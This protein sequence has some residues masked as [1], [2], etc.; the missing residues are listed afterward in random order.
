MALAR[1]QLRLLAAL[2]C[3]GAVVWLS[4]GSR[5][6]FGLFLQP[7][8]S[9]LGWGREVF[10]FALAL[11]NLMWGLAQ[12]FAGMVADRYGSG[13]VLVAG[14]AVYALGLV[15]MSQTGAAWHFHLGAGVLVGLALAATSFAVVLSAVGRLVAPERRGLAFGIVTAVGSFGQFA[16]VP[17][18]Q[19]FLAAYGWPTAFLILAAFALL[20]VPLAT[21]LTGR[22][23]PPDAGGSQ[24][25][26]QAL[27]EAAH[28]DGFRY[29]TLG[30]FVCGFQVA[31]IAVHLPASLADSGIATSVAAWAL[32]LVGLFNVVGSLGCGV[33]GDRFSKK[34]LLSLL[35][36][37][38]AVVIVAFLWMPLSTVSVL[39]FA[40]VM[41]LLWLGTVP[42]TS[43]LVSQIFGTRHMGTLFGIVFLS[44]QLGSFLGV[45]LGGYLYDTTGSYAPVWW[46]A[47]VLGVVAAVLHWPIDD[48]PVARLA[49]AVD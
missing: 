12:P 31:F 47:V 36:L 17:A 15:V 43:G 9:D 27:V 39:A 7:I 34:Y 19:A 14:A 16:M 45:W 41:G 37:A 44:H 28:H 24:G 2:A 40:S 29:L 49:A 38:R 8:T 35:Y 26:R 25:L 13:R 10:A 46:T 6:S 5:Q 4:V 18:G 32:S 22:Q 20:I 33:L 11:Q 42:L 30:F 3:G 23:P 1:P 48:R 21:A